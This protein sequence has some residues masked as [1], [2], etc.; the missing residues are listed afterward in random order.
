VAAVAL[1]KILDQ[2]ALL[3]A[4][5]NKPRAFVEQHFHPRAVAKSYLELYEEILF[6]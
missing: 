5:L 1:Q 2:P 4:W 6:Q 3:H